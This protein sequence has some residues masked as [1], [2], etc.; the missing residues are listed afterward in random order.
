MSD[1]KQKIIQAAAG[2]F[3]E[4]GVAPV[5]LQQIADQAEV[6]VGNLAYHFKNKEVII[7]AV[8]EWLS[9]EVKHVLQ[10][11]RQSP[12]LLDF[13]H[14]LSHWFAFNQSYAFYFSAMLPASVA[15]VA[16]LRAQSLSRLLSQ[17]NKRFEY[18]IQRGV[19]QTDNDPHHYAAV[20][21]SIGLAITHWSSYQRIRGESSDEKKFKRVIWSQ[22]RPYF[23]TRG[24]AEYQVLIHP[25]V[26]PLP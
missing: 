10:R 19:M 9:V 12:T 22:W 2:L 20:A 17:L 18:H 4:Y 26:S 7:Q 16:H 15:A 6:S 24:R 8:Y 23:T 25:I 5:R 11:F 21:E 1:T 3:H 13:D 14:Q